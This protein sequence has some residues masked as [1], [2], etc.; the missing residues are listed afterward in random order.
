MAGKKAQ[1][2]KVTCRVCGQQY[3]RITARHLAAAH[4]MTLTEYRRVYESHDPPVAPP[5]A[6]PVNGSM[7]A[8]ATPP[9]APTNGDT[10]DAPGPVAL[11]NAQVN[12]GELFDNLADWLTNDS[13]LQGLTARVADNLLQEDGRKLKVLLRA[14]VGAKMA[15]MS[16][17]L[18]A[19]DRIEARLYD[20]DKIQ[21]M[22]TN[23]LLQLKRLLHE[24]GNDFVSLIKM[25]LDLDKPVTGTP[26]FNFQTLIQ[27]RGQIVNTAQYPGMPED[28]QRREELRQ[29][30]KGLTRL[31]AQPV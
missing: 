2:P 3:K 23:Q 25:I 17:M 18:L 16:D 7:A 1:R 24:E 30:I 27:Q 8:H 21:N 29:A 19:L 14:Q 11:T 20:P 5:P 10:P 15:R 9:P 6:P 22:S 12:R 4:N 13:P 31:A 28:P 26:Q